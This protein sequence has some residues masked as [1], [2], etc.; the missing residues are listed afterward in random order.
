M[1]NPSF[2]F[3]LLKLKVP[4]SYAGT[5]WFKQLLETEAKLLLALKNEN[6]IESEQSSAKAIISS[7]KKYSS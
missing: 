5:K 7:S 4:I 6:K 1:I 3:P 2:F